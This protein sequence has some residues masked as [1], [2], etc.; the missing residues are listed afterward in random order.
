MDIRSIHFIILG[1]LS[2]GPKHGYQIHKQIN[3]P[4]G[5]GVIWKIKITNVYGLLDVLE[6]KGYIKPSDQVVDDT[7][8]PPKKYFEV[9]GKGKEVFQTWLSEPVKHGREMRQVF[10]S[11][12][13]F[14]TILGSKNVHQLILDQLEECKQWLENM[15]QIL[16]DEPPFVQTVKTFRSMQFKS[17]IEWLEELK[18]QY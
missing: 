1:I 5:I 2:D 10:L 6:K 3:D 7:S 14:A 11:K 13:Y 18:E 17:Y 15:D 16:P 12:F 8:Y 9:T 4:E